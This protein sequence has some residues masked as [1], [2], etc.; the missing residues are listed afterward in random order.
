[1]ER[2]DDNI[3]EADILLSGEEP[4]EAVIQAIRSMQEMNTARCRKNVRDPPYCQ[5]VSLS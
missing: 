3:P 1:M 5:L 4:P 2:P